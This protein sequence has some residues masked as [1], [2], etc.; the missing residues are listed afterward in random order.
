MAGESTLSSTNRKTY[1]DE[2][3]KA[4]ALEEYKLMSLCTVD[5]SSA[6][7]STYFQRTNTVEATGGG[8]GSPINGIP[9]MAPFPYIEQP[10]VSV[11]SITQKWAAESILPMETL[12]MATV[13]MLREIVRTVSR[14]V[15]YAVDRAILAV[16]SASYGNTYA[17]T[18]GN[19]WDSATV[20]NRDPVKDILTAIQTL[21]TDN[22]NVEDGEV[23][24]VVNGTDYV[25]I[26]SNSK[27]TNNPSFKT[28]DV[29]SNG[30]M[31]Q[32]AGA[33]IMVTDVVAA[34]TAYIVKSKEAL[35]FKQVEALTTATI[36]DPGKST[37]V[38]AWMQGA[39]QIPVPNA[40]CKITNTRA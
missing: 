11:S 13:P 5:S 19:E 30:V 32:V 17:I 10:L 8:T 29:V 3:I 4:V 26:L 20:A 27:F 36:E 37:T 22:I 28:A 33:K 12:Q 14:T 25:N 2:A 23:Y 24:L 15:A 38:R 34:D 16:L 39:I 40:V 35:T 6:W 21:R 1:I 9:Q 7:I 18:A 31:G